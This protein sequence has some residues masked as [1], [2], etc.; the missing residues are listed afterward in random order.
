MMFRKMQTAHHN[1]FDSRTGMG[2]RE[3]AR[4]TERK[5]TAEWRWVASFSA[6]CLHAAQAI[7]RGKNFVN[8][9]LA[10]AISPSA[11][12]LGEEIRAAGPFESRFWRHLNALGHQIE[13]NRELASTAIRKTL[14]PNST[15]EATIARLAT[16]IGQL[17]SAMQL[18]VP[19]MV[20]EL[21]RRSRPLRE[22]WDAYGFGMLKSIGGRTDE[23]LVIERAEIVL[24]YPVT[25]GGGAA[26]L[27]NNSVR[28]EAVLT[29]NVPQLPEVVRLAWLVAQV[30]NDLPMFSEKLHADRLA[31]VASMAMLPATLQAAQELELCSDDSSLLTL[32]V[33]SWI[34]EPLPADAAENLALWW[35][36]YQETRPA[37][38]TA[39]QALDKMLG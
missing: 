36:T 27:V 16:L 20:D 14:G 2:S 11:V 15:Q 25:G 29:N 21:T 35:Q 32:A 7:L 3:P 22:L 6:S 33:P 24:V 23:R 38:D 17:E 10:E 1:E 5:M 13:N 9:Q 39:L 37:W 26:Q 19:Q 8:P 31:L 30:N 4:T 34:E 12:A 28:I 18:A